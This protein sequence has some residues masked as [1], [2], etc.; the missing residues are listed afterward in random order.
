M[1]KDKTK[2]KKEP[3]RKPKYGMLS[4]IGYMLKLM[5][6]ADKSIAFSAVATVPVRL[7]LSAIGLYMPTVI[8]REL[9]VSSD[10][11]WIVAVICGFVMAQMIF[12][13]VQ[14]AVK[15]NIDISEHLV[16]LEMDAKLNERLYDED[17]FLNLDSDYKTKQERAKAV[18]ANN[19]TAG[20][21]FV[22]Y[23]ADIVVHILSFALFGTVV[24]GLSPLLLVVLIIG[25][26]VDFR[27]G[28]W[29]NEK[30]WAIRDEKNFIN[31]KMNYIGQKVSRDLSYGKDIRLFGL[32]GYLQ[33]LVKKLSEKWFDNQ[34]KSEKYSFT[35]AM[36]S[37]LVVLVRDGVAYAF[38]IMQAAAG[39]I[40]AA[41]FLLY[42]TAVS[43]LSGFIMGIFNTWT[44]MQN[45]A[46][47]VSD[48][49]EYFD[50]K[51][52]LNRGKGIDLPKGRPLSIEF[53]D[54]SFRYPSGEKQI[55]DHVSFKIEAGEKIALVGTN[56]AGKTTLTKLMCGLLVPDEG[57]VLIDGHSIYEYN[58]DELYTLFSLIPQ[59][60]HFLP[61]TIA[62]NIALPD[63]DAGEDIDREKLARCIAEAG[64]AEKIASLPLGADTPLNRQ[65]YKN[66]TELSGGEQQKL[67]L[68]RAMYRG[69]E[70]MILDEPTAALDP[71]AEDS[72]Y[73]RYNS[74]KGVTSVFISHRLAS[75]RFCDRIFF[76][77]G[78][79]IAEEGT[80]DE[81]MEKCGKY[82]EIFDVQAKYYK[83]DVSDE[84]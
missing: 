48:F 8:L 60:Y 15:K 56:G 76:L 22:S 67:L 75:T 52:K 70:I 41:Q 29:L 3:K 74:I 77:D 62:E 81:L 14:H 36:V 34:E 13:L 71:I 17:Q 28:V 54:V 50:E 47:G 51:D 7:I 72:M 26:I 80:H 39:E 59:N 20:V 68:S 43:S 66:A 5:W 57:E 69:A 38:L 1:K 65:V 30:N 21:H 55:L 10:F 40:D 16:L 37:L 53:R 61:M 18:T 45:G 79:V 2:K 78:A 24:A 4:C 25:C 58:R 83:E 33:E 82:R 44:K 27:M 73:R 35:A 31:K 9:E 42:F 11:A 12:S 49:R 63:R 32:A 6:G 23:F 64:L 84:K 46:L 19:H